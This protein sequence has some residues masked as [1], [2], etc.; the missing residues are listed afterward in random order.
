MEVNQVGRMFSISFLKV[1]FK[2]SFQLKP[3][4]CS[5]LC[6][7]PFVSNLSLTTFSWFY[8]VSATV[9]SYKQQ[10]LCKRKFTRTV[11]AQRTKEASDKAWRKTELTQMLAVQASGPTATVMVQEEPAYRRLTVIPLT[12]LIHLPS[13]SPGKTD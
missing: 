3:G 5:R 1:S 9:L 6:Y 4:N 11:G 13:Q 12:S 7:L 8:S 2:P 10:K